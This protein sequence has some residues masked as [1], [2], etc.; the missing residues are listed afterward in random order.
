M[1]SK[2]NQLQEIP[3]KISIAYDWN[4][5]KKVLIIWDI[6]HSLD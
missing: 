2:F 6:D 3:Y 4:N 1:L 5:D